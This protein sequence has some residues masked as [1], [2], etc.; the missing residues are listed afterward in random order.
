[1]DKAL[2]DF[3]DTYVLVDHKTITYMLLS[4]L[5]LMTVKKARLVMTQWH[6]K[7]KDLGAMYYVSGSSKSTVPDEENASVERPAERVI[8][9]IR[10]IQ[11]DALKEQETSMV[12]E[13]C[14]IYAIG[15]GKTV[16]TALVYACE[17]EARELEIKRALGSLEASKVYGYI[18]NTIVNALE[19][20][21]AKRM[22]QQEVVKPILK[23]SATLPV[24]S[25]VE[26]AV[27]PSFKRAATNPL[28]S[29]FTKTPKPKAKVSRDSSIDTIGTEKAQDEPVQIQPQKPIPSTVVKKLTKKEEETQAE[30]VAMMMEDDVK[31]AEMPDI[32]WSESDHEK[33]TPAITAKP[34]FK[35]KVKKQVSTKDAKG[36]LVT[37]EETVWVSCSE[38]EREEVKPQ[39]MP[40]KKPKMKG[41]GIAGFFKKA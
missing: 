3:L 17:E 9:L 27:V 26:E 37:R 29:S 41:Q 33:E 38:E 28:V 12:I 7:H 25:E 24:K 2:E 22:K 31:D 6:E 4:R 34:R 11:K 23:S 20:D 30:L 36:Y 39:A 35:K 32:E 19:E 21:P 10:L 5:K 18:N 13:S 1:M 8:Y 40:R 15:P 16:D 14:E